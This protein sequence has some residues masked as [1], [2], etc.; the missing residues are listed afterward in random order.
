[1]ISANCPCINC[2]I[3]PMCNIKVQEKKHV[4]P[5]FLSYVL[6]CKKFD[7]YI[8][9]NRIGGWDQCRKLRKRIFNV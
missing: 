3:F 6:T 9:D 1:M 8:N 5:Y 2:I 4:S 7:M